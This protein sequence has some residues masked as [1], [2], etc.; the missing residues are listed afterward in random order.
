MVTKNLNVISKQESLEGKQDAKYIKQAK[1]E[2][3]ETLQLDQNMVN[4][5]QMADALAKN[6]FENGKN[7]INN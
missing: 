5:N 7:G 6:R 4:R 2:L 1:E 3:L